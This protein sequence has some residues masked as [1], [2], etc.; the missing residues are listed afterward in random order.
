M[1]QKS[2]YWIDSHCFTDNDVKNAGDTND[3]KNVQD[4]FSKSSA[5]SRLELHGGSTCYYKDFEDA[6]FGK[7]W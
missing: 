5:G 3:S 7:Y 2:S 6:M 1:K 4:N